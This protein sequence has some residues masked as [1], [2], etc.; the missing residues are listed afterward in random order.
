M[1]VAASSAHCALCGSAS[2]ELIAPQA[3]PQLSALSSQ[4]SSLS[5]SLRLYLHQLSRWALQTWTSAREARARAITSAA[6]RR[7]AFGARVG[8]ASNS[9]PTTP[10]ATVFPLRC[11]LRAPLALFHFLLLRMPH[12]PPTS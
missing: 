3:Q 10:P 11:P 4:L 12:P 8:A 6:T 1:L 7:A 2:C 9:T 5:F